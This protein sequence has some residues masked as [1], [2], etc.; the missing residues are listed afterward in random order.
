MICSLQDSNSLTGANNSLSLDEKRGLEQKQ[1]ESVARSRV[2][3]A[4]TNE[5]RDR[6]FHA[7]S[8]MYKGRSSSSLLRWTQFQKSFS[9]V[10]SMVSPLVR[11]RI[12]ASELTCVMLMLFVFQ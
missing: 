12:Q 1:V 5:R 8:P 11:V 6:V 3:L 9:S 4:A 7:L 10:C 2:M